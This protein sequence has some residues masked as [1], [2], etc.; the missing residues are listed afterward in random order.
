MERAGAEM[1]AYRIAYDGRS[2]HGFQRQPEVPTIE[3]ALGDALCTLDILDQERDVPDEY[4]AA[5]RTDAGVSALAQTVAFDAPPWLSPSALNAELPRDIRAWARRE[6][7]DSFHATHDAIRRVYTYY[8]YAPEASLD[9]AR[10]AAERLSG[11]ADW[12]NL[13]PATGDTVREITIRVDRDDAMLVVTCTGPGF[14][15]ELVRRIVSLIGAIASGAATLERI[16][17][18]RSAEPLDGPDGIAPAPPEPLVLT[19]VQY[20]HVTFEPDPAVEEDCRSI[21]EDRARTAHANACVMGR[22]VDGLT[23]QTN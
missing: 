20:P 5:G 23:R 15:H 18:V 17:R 2:Y 11:E 9:R 1:D 13:T 6:V 21:F 14:L 22:I 16:E 12:H 3:G 7:S 19:D 10:T 8:L 4:A